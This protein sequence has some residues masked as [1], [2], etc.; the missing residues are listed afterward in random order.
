MKAADVRPIGILRR[1]LF[2]VKKSRE[3]D[4]WLGR[5]SW[6]PFKVLLYDEMVGVVTSRHVSENNLLY[7][8]FTVLP[9]TEPELLPIEFLTLWE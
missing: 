1:K 7:A 5:F 8:N 3:T 2:S 6:T 4:V 9:S